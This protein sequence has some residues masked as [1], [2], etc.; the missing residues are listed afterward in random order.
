MIEEHGGVC[1]HLSINWVDGSATCTAIG[2]Q[3]TSK[4]SFSICLLY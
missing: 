4:A 2:K 3:S 1:H